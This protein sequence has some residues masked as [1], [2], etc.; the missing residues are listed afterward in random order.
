MEAGS[1]AD[2]YG[3]SLNRDAQQADPQADLKG[4]EMW[5]HD[6]WGDETLFFSSVWMKRPRFDRPF[7]RLRNRS[8]GWELVEGLGSVIEEAGEAGFLFGMYSREVW[9]RH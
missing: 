2:A 7:V 1:V 9:R 3:S 8:A 4:E 5:V 6:A